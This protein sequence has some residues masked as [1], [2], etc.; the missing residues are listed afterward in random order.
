[1]SSVLRLAFLC[2]V[3]CLGL[4]CGLFG[5]D[6]ER[7]D[8]PV[9]E[10]FTV[11]FT[12]DSDN[13]CPPTEDCTVD[14]APSPVRVELPTIDIV[15][16]VDVAEITGNEQLRDGAQRI[17]SVTINSVGFEVLTND[18]NI[19]TPEL[20]LWVGPFIATSAQ[21]ATNVRL[22]TIPSVPPGQ[23]LSDELAV[24]EATAAAVSDY[25]RALRFSVSPYAEPA[26]EE[27]ELFPAQ[28]GTDL[29][30]TFNMTFVLNPTD[31]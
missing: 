22:A 1:M 8:I 4:G 24:D 31:L 3:L 26:I 25:L 5:D 30:V 28:G 6:E 12:I 21:A 9:N 18:L 15:N 10:S 2:T 20:E 13:L 16:P 29:A 7:F 17:K 11:T 23:T 27:G 19:P 14:P